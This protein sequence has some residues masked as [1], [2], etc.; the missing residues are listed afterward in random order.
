MSKHH[1]L[2]DLEHEIDG[3][4]T[5]AGANQVSIHLHGKRQAVVYLILVEQVLHDRCI[6]GH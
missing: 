6:V 3:V 1:D 4:E 5:G 2:E